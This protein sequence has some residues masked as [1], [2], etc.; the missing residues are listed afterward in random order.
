MQ[1]KERE[2]CSDHGQIRLVV[3]FLLGISEQRPDCPRLFALE[4]AYLFRLNIVRSKLCPKRHVAWS[5]GRRSSPID[6]V[7]YCELIFAFCKK[8]FILAFYVRGIGWLGGIVRIVWKDG[9]CICS[10]DLENSLEN[11]I[12][13]N[14][15]ATNSNR[16]SP[17]TT[18]GLNLSPAPVRIDSCR[19][20]LWH[21]KRALCKQSPIL[22]CSLLAGLFWSSYIDFRLS[23]Y[24]IPLLGKQ[25]VCSL[26]WSLGSPY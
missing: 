6:L 1:R 4:F 7:Y 20:R 26:V 9:D 5:I 24:V 14:R 16:C 10:P 19:A 22:A 25:R 2:L 21:W 17:I 13:G 18:I 11:S 12:D 15:L 8:V 23:V 3:V